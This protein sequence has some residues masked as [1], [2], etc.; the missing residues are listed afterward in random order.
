MDPETTRTALAAVAAAATVVISFL[1]Y[2]SLRK[3]GQ[4]EKLEGELDS[5]LT[6]YGSLYEVEEE[7]LSR[8]EKAGLG[9]KKTLKKN[10]RK[11]VVGR[12]PKIELTADGVKKKKKKFKLD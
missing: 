8:M 6:Q 3:K 5:T 4:I 10:V 9:N 1:G 12:G 7:L 2:L 11:E